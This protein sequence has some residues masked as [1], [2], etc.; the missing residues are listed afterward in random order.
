MITLSLTHTFSFISFSFL[1]IWIGYG[2]VRPKLI[3]VESIS[4]AVIT[5]LYFSVGKFCI[6]W[7]KYRF[8][9][10]LHF[11]LFFF[12][13]FFSNFIWSFKYCIIRCSSKYKPKV[14]YPPFLIDHFLILCLFLC[15]RTAGMLLPSMFIDFLFLSWIYLALSSTIRLRFLSIIK[16]CYSILYFIFVGFWQ[17]FNK[18][19]SYKCMKD[20]I[21]Q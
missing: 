5:I 3:W 2:I 16:S 8:V 15:F 18:V 12:S 21:I 7:N 14:N 17:N 9:D 4:V 1:F 13:S 11:K 20:Y 19:T 6:L 10:F